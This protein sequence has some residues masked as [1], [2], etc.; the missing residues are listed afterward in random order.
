MSRHVWHSSAC[1]HASEA[2][3]AAFNAYRPPSRAHVAN[4]FPRP[5]ITGRKISP[6]LLRRVRSH[7]TRP[8]LYAPPDRV[9]RV[10]ETLALPALGF[11]CRYKKV[12]PWVFEELIVCRPIQRYGGGRRRTLTLNMS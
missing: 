4:R 6:D 1:F 7:R 5:E 12:A 9:E 3:T 11:V 10:E 2:S 8:G